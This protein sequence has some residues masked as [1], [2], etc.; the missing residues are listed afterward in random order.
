MTPSGSP[1]QTVVSATGA[2]YKGFGPLASLPLGN[3]TTETRNFDARYSPSEIKLTA[4]A[5]PRLDWLY[6]TDKVG[7]PLAITDAL[8][9]ANNRAFTYQDIQYFLAS[10]AGPWPGPLAWTFDKIGNR[11]TETRSGLTDTYTYATNTT[12]GHSPIIQQITPGA[13]GTA[14]TPSRRGHLAEINAAGNRVTVTHDEAGQLGKF[15]LRLTGTVHLDF[16]STTGIPRPRRSP[17]PGNSSSPLWHLEECLGTPIRRRLRKRRRLRL[18]RQLGTITPPPAAHPPPQRRSSTPPTAP[19][20]CSTRSR[21]TTP[22]TKS[23]TSL[24]DRSLSS[25]SMATT[26]PISGSPPITWEHRSL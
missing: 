4:G 9:A 11:L 18:G 23:S 14:P 8:A 1:A 5:T 3:G 21:E 2:T 24:E 6:T 15:S 26:K 7:N 17:H 19:L 12:G 16:P 10:A 13:G 22:R 25:P 20:A